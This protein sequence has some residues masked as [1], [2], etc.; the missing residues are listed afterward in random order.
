LGNCH[1]WSMHTSPPDVVLLLR[2]SR[3][4]ESWAAA[5]VTPFKAVTVVPGAARAAGLG[6]APG[7]GRLHAH[8]SG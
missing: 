1:R 4:H 7:E 2:A 8:R 6:P 3:S 5:L